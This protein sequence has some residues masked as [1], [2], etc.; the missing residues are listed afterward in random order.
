MYE[1][2]AHKN[3]F[4]VIC[5]AE[6]K[7]IDEICR[8]LQSFLKKHEIDRHFFTVSLG[9]R[10]LISNAIRHGCQNNSSHQVSFSINLEGAELVIRVEDPGPG[11]DWRHQENCCAKSKDTSG[12]GISIFQQYFDSY[13]YNDTGNKLEL[14]KKVSGESQS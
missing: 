10:E 13:N 11:F 5:S 8:H 14:R 4:S 9:V 12:R 2:I 7:N 6:F 1:T 3:G